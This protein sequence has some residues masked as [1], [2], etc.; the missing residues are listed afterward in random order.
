MKNFFL[1]FLF[2]CA[3]FILFAQEGKSK[4]PALEGGIFGGPANFQWKPI[5]E[6]GPDFQNYYNDVR[7]GWTFGAQLSYGFNRYL[8]CG[9]TASRFF[10]EASRDSLL[11]EIPEF[12]IKTKVNVSTRTIVYTVSPVVKAAYPFPFGLEVGLQ[13]GPSLIFYRSRSNNVVDT[14][15]IK[16]MC[17]GWLAAASIGYH[18]TSRFV[19]STQFAYMRS[20]LKRYISDD[21]VKVET[22]TLSKDE[23][24]DI[25]RIEYELGICYRIP[26]RR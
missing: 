13:A 26:L 3:P 8:A 5:A 22:V 6:L 14:S 23:Y 19:I 11:I 15:S 17:P 20:T 2:F 24:Q 1:L 25:S 10:T 9:I 21:G 4:F 18:L 7:K 12:H 16:G